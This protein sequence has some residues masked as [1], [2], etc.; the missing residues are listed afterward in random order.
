MNDEEHNSESAPALA[1]A[2]LRR[3]EPVLVIVIIL[4]VVSCDEG[5]Q[6]QDPLIGSWKLDY[7]EVQIYDETVIT[8]H[9]GG[10]LEV[11]LVSGDITITAE[12]EWR[13]DNN[14][15]II[16]YFEPAISGMNVLTLA[17]T[18][19]TSMRL[20]WKTLHHPESEASEE[21]DEV[22]YNRV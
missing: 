5:T 14:L 15:L 18:L 4:M 2:T 1:L 7:Q 3:S 6:Q 13:Y 17:V 9:Q 16:R 11:T 8:F 21:Y 12:G 22:C 20:C 10:R 19:K